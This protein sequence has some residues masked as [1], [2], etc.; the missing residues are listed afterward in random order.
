MLPVKLAGGTRWPAQVRLPA[1]DVR[2]A[3]SGWLAS[4]GRVCSAKEVSLGVREYSPAALRILPL[5]RRAKGDQPV[6]IAGCVEAY[7]EMD[8]PGDGL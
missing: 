8:A 5:A 1:A 6:Q 4:G 3:Q 7:I 2:S